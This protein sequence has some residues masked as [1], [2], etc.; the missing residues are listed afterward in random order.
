[1]RLKGVTEEEWETLLNC[2]SGAGKGWIFGSRV[3]GTPQRYSDIDV[4]LD[5]PAGS[6]SKLTELKEKC[7]ES[8]LPFRVDIS[9]FY[10]LPSEWQ[11]TIRKS[12]IFVDF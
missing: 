1:L 6:Y 3:W 4:A 7:E 10:S 11:E 5:I 9:A 2:L 12:G 8:N